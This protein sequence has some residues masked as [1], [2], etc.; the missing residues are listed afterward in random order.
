MT[1]LFDL[2]VPLN[3]TPMLENVENDSRF[4]RQISAIWIGG[5][6]DE[7]AVF[8]LSIISFSESAEQ[9][10]VRGSLTHFYLWLLSNFFSIL[11]EYTELKN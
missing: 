3:S 4:L 5:F 7:M 11:S 10:G 2:Q 1:N 8:E 9:V 6:I